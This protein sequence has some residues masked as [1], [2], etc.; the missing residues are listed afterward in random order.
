LTAGADGAIVTNLKC[1][2]TANSGAKRCNIFIST[3]AG[4]TWKLHESGLMASYSV[5]N[6]TVQT[7]ITFVDKTDP[8]K[9]IVLQASAKIG[10]TVQVA[11]AVV[12][13]AEYQD[14]S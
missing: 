6:T 2:A 8:Y 1:W 11:E 10:V 13:T 12:F 7:P 9:A 5:A 14:L 4:S 3:D